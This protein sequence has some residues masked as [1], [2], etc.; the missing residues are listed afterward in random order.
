MTVATEHNVWA[1]LRDAVPDDEALAAAVATEL[2]EP[3][4]RVRPSVITATL[5]AGSTRPWSSSGRWSRASGPA[6]AWRR[7]FAGV[8]A[9]RGSGQRRLTSWWTRPGA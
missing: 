7:A 6:R 4:D 5:V 9:G 3:L 8:P 1:I 2:R